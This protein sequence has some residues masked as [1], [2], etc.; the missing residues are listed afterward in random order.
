MMESAVA[1]MAAC[2]SRAS[3]RA[4]CRSS[5]TRSRS[6]WSAVTSSLVVGGGATG[7]SAQ[8]RLEG[9]HGIAQVGRADDERV[10]THLTREVPVRFVHVGRGDE[11]D[12]DAAEGRIAAGL[13]AEGEAIHRRHHDVGQDG[14]RSAAARD[15]E[16]LFAPGRRL[17]LVPG[18]ARAGTPRASGSAARRRRRGSSARR[19]RPT[20]GA[21]WAWTTSSSCDGS[22]G[23]ARTW[24]APPP[25]GAQLLQARDHARDDDG[26]QLRRAGRGTDLGQ[27]LQAV[28][29]GEHVVEDQE[30]RAGERRPAPGPSCHRRRRRRRNP[31]SRG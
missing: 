14:I 4:V 15:L 7:R 28:H 18:A 5:W 12:R 20:A 16:G 19:V 1:W 17:H 30:V 21:S 22:T 31:R 11:D 3:L 24:V 10:R 27:Q 23:L 6:W 13:A 26:R 29:V 8:A 25:C 9:G 2:R